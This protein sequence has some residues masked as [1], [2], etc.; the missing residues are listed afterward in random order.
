MPVI[1]LCFLIA[2]KSPFE[3]SSARTFSCE[4]NPEEKTEIKEGKPAFRMGLQPL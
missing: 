4:S 1:F 2:N 3:T